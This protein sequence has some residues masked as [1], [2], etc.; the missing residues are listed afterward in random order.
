M[1]SR[2]IKPL[3]AIDFLS[4]QRKAQGLPGG[5]LS[6]QSTDGSVRRGALQIDVTDG[7]A[8]CY[9]S[10]LYTP[11]IPHHRMTGMACGLG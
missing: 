10:A 3:R 8:R 7:R 4:A 6:T 2:E 9:A 11:V 1:F 5:V